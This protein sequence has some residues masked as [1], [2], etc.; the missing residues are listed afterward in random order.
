[1][2][3]PRI[4]VFPGTFDPITLGHADLVERAAALFD[5]VI[6][7]VAAEGRKTMFTLKERL[8]M[9]TEA[10]AEYPHVRAMAF[11]GLLTDF[12]LRHDATAFVRGIRGSRDWDYEMQMAFANRGLA[13]SIDTVFLPPSPGTS[14]I[15]GT[16]VREVARLGGDVG[17]WVSPS[18]ADAL[19]AKTGP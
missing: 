12:G 15:T 6:V 8:A 11:D 10:V 4:A 1:M 2:S 18:V 19:I 13:P 16:L 3:T 7:A 14:W 5:Q 9:V 17:S